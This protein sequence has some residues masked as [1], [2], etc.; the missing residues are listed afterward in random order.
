MNSVLL[1]VMTAV[2]FGFGYRYYAKLLAAGVFRPFKYNTSPVDAAGTDGATIDR[3]PIVGHHL[4]ALGA[5]VVVGVAVA[6]GW[7]WT[8]AFL[9]LVVGAVVVGGVFGYALLWLSPGRPGA[10]IAGAA[11]IFS[12]AARATFFL[13]VTLLVLAVNGVIAVVAG[14]LL[15]F[16]PD[17]PLALALLLLLSLALGRLANYGWVVIAIAVLLGFV[18]IG[19]GA[20]VPIELAGALGIQIGEETVAVIDGATLWMA[21]LF[22]FLFAAIRLPADRLARPL[23]VMATGM[24]VVIVVTVTLGILLSHPNLTAPTFHAAG[25]PPALPFVFATLAVG[26]LA[27]TYVLAATQAHAAAL[28]AAA[29][30]RRLGYGGALLCAGLAVVV[31]IAG[32]TAFSSTAE[33]TAAYPVWRQAEGLTQPVALVLAACARLAAGLGLDPGYARTVM[34]VAWS[35]LALVGIDMGLR[36]LQSLL[37]ETAQIFHLPWSGDYPRTL[38]WTGM[39]S[40]LVIYATGADTPVGWVTLGIVALTTGA[41]ALAVVAIAAIQLQRP[42]GPVLGA[43]ALLAGASIFALAAGI[44]GA[45]E[46]AQWAWVAAG[47]LFGAAELWLLFQA[48]RKLTRGWP[49]QPA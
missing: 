12:P 9:T 11:V 47:G 2:V 19:W 28:P 33:W 30:A 20:S 21:L 31:L 3:R 48:L 35:M 7:G 40:A 24:L 8:P 43:G 27:G 14:R 17:A 39:I 1:L 29:D 37:K 41:L 4:A 46:R 18:L 32:T 36:Y 22:V 25:G 16:Q 23:G 10:S 45:A 26:G 44:I 42:A 38:A 34:V 15:A 13:L 5:P 6:A 49:G